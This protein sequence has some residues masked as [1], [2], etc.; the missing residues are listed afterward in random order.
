MLVFRQVNMDYSIC[1]AL[2]YNSSNMTR[3]LLLYDI[4]CQWH[5]RLAARLKHAKGFISLPRGLVLEGGIGKFHVGAHIDEC[6]WKFSPNFLVG[7]GQVDGEILE[8]LWAR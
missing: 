7:V 5:K 2:G 6:F 3:G 4:W 8:T 1:N